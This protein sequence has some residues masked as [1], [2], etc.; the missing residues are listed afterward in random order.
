MNFPTFGRPGTILSTLIP[1]SFVLLNLIVA[2]CYLANW[3]VMG[4]IFNDNKYFVIL[5]FFCFAYLIGIILK[6]LKVQK[7]D[8]K[9]AEFLVKRRLKK[10]KKKIKKIKKKRTDES[11]IQKKI[12]KIKNRKLPS[13]LTDEFPFIKWIGVVADK[14]LPSGAKIFYAEFWKPYIRNRKESNRDFFN[15]CKTLILE[16]STQFAQ[17]IFNMESEVRYVASMYYSMRILIYLAPVVILVSLLCKD[18]I[19]SVIAFSLLVLYI[20]AIKELLKSLRLLRIKEVTEIFMMT[21]AL[22]EEL[23][24]FLK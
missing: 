24:P 19:V 12:D 22:K 18:W 17:S 13:Y 2:V 1:G 8:R 20:I 9:S 7:A 5:L 10:W 16:H 3:E 4:G 15:L 21:Y 6:L 11:V 23:A 14:K